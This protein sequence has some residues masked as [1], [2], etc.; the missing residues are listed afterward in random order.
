M[1]RI[2]LLPL[3]IMYALAAHAGVNSLRVEP[4]T[5][6]NLTSSLAQIGKIVLGENDVLLYDKSG[7][8]IGST[9][10]SQFEKIVF[11]E[12]DPTAIDEVT[13]P[14]VQVFYDAAQESLFVRGIEGKQTVRV[15]SV[16]GQLLQ[17]TDATNGE[18]VMH[19]GGLQN[20]AYLLQVGAQVVKFV[21]E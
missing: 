12:S 17:S 5:G 20:G 19:I 11:Y 1:K 3:V 13:I 6:D 2:L 9:P 7:A 15:F 21:K 14:S 18:A 8:Q 10:F 16:N 4:L